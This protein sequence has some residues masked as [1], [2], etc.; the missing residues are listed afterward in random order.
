MNSNITGAGII[1]YNYTGNSVLLVRIFKGN[2]RPSSTHGF[3]KG[4]CE[5][6]DG[7]FINTALRE[8]E[9]ETGIKRSQIKSLDKQMMGIFTIYFKFQCIEP[10]DLDSL[11][12]NQNEIYS[13][14]WYH[15]DVVSNML[16]KRGKN[17]GLHSDVEFFVMLKNNAQECDFRFRSVES[18]FNQNDLPMN[19]LTFKKFIY[20]TTNDGNSGDSDSGSSQHSSGNI[21][22]DSSDD[23]SHR[24]ICRCQTYC[25]PRHG[26]CRSGSWRQAKKEEDINS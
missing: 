12:Y 14:E 19:S 23:I 26:K 13:R 1:L 10:I 6:R 7:T 17:R 3:P 18:V 9:E 16:Y 24:K 15:L 25:T 22:S 21:S 20:Q 11:S 5:V 8:L 2:R 4:R